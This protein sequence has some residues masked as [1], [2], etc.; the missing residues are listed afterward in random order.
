MKK[1]IWIIIVIAVIVGGYYAFRNSDVQS[2]NVESNV[3]EVRGTVLSVNGEQ[4]ALDG[5]YVVTIE[6]E[7]G[8]AT[9]EVPSMGILLCP[10]YEAGNLL[11]ID[12]I[13]AGEEIEVRG[14]VSESGAIVPCESADHY[15]R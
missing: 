9:V 10:A 6:T 12:E 2:S 11:S 7:D 1:I 15:I 3:R 14:S 8:Q 4:V 13:R 5:P